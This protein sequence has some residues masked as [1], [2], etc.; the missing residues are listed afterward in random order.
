MNNEKNNGIPLGDITKYGLVAL[1]VITAFAAGAPHM[2]D[3]LE[4]V[5]P[6]SIVTQFG[7]MDMKI[8]ICENIKPVADLVLKGGFLGIVTLLG[9]EIALSKLFPKEH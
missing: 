7:G 3:L 2:I 4:Q 9:G 8:P 5:S 6:D 1:G